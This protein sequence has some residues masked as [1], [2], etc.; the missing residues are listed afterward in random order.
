[1]RGVIGVI[2]SEGVWDMLIQYKCIKDGTRQCDII[3]FD[4]LS[5]ALNILDDPTPFP[6]K[7]DH[8]VVPFAGR[9]S[10]VHR[11]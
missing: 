10:A 3:I 6:A 2:S 9:R 4:T 11:G 7:L 5:V 1:M 8:A